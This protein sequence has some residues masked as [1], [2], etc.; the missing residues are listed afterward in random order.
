MSKPFA[1]IIEDHA[2]SAIIFAEALKSTGYE[3]DIAR[4]G[5]EA[6]ERLGATT[7]D[8]VMLDLHARS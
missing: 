5:S 7:P 3:T 6:L 8:V 1:L 4:S 2:D